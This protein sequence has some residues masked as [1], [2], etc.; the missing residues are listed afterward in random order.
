MFFDEEENAWT[1]LDYKT[2]IN[3][4]GKKVK[5]EHYDGQLRLYAQAV[6]AMGEKVSACFLYGVRHNDL[7]KIGISEVKK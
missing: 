6:E 2:D 7:F 4:D 1:L 5:E 3:L